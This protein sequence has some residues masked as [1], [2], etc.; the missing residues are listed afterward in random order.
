MSFV[1][2]MSV[3]MTFTWTL[4]NM[5]LITAYEIKTTPASIHDSQIDLSK[6]G[7]ILT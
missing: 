6:P 3:V 2:V 4:W 1:C 7:L 5:F